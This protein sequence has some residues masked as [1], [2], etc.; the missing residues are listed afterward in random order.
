MEF[1]LGVSL[2]LLQ[3]LDNLQASSQSDHYKTRRCR[4]VTYPESYVTK[5]TTY[6]K[7]RCSKSVGQLPK[8]K[9]GLN[10][11]APAGLSGVTGVPRS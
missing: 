4:G 8:V 7:K 9:L 2:R 10:L 1:L 6:T 3:G 11:A 5:Y